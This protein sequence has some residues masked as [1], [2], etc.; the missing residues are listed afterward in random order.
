[1]KIVPSDATIADL[2]K[3]AAAYEDQTRKQGGTIAARLRE[4]AKQCRRWVAEL[5]SG[6]WIS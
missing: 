3:K 5:K 6:K 1:M 4:K 2:K